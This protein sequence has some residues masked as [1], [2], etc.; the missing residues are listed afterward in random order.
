MN[1]I[2]SPGHAHDVLYFDQLIDVR[3]LSCPLPIFNTKT[4]L[5]NLKSGE[6]VKILTTD[7][8]SALFFESMTRQTGLE[9]L[10]W[11]AHDGEFVFYVSKPKHV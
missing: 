8:H 3:G 7:R 4:S 5:E 11:G 2:K 9:L 6:V 1:T 10:T